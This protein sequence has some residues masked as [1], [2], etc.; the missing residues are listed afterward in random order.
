MMKV[1]LEAIQP[2]AYRGASAAVVLTAVALVALGIFALMTNKVVSTPL[3]GGMIGGGACLL[4]ALLIINKCKGKTERKESIPASSSL[5]TEQARLGSLQKRAEDQTKKLE[6]LEKRSD[7]VIKKLDAQE[8]IS[9]TPSPPT[10]L[11]PDGK[12]NIGAPGGQSKDDTFTVK[13]GERPN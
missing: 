9:D 4:I 6:D 5:D 7:A 13:L 1:S 12:G 8:K 2:Y 11:D 10:P 3:A